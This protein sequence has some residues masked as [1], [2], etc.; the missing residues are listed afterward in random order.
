MVE[1]P[2]ES[3]APVHDR[4]EIQEGRQRLARS[5]QESAEMERAK[6]LLRLLPDLDQAKSA[7]LNS[8]SAIRC[9]PRR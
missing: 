3:A 2:G 1:R 4:S 8:L 5:T 6:T 9:G 7:V